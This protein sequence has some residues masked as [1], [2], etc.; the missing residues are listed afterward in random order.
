M[1]RENRILAPDAFSRYSA[2][3]S[4]KSRSTLNNNLRYRKLER[5]DLAC[6]MS[7]FLRCAKN[8][9]GSRFLRREIHGYSSYMAIR[10]LHLRANVGKKQTVWTRVLRPGGVYRNDAK[11]SQKYNL[12]V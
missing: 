8:L 12:C 9:V 10:E 1:Q 11:I 5:C 7:T 2:S 3:H 6:E 4:P